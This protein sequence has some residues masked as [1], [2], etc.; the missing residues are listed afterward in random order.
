M[1]MHNLLSTSAER[2]FIKDRDSRFVAVSAGWL[3]AFAGGLSLA[4]VI[5]RTD[6]DFFSAE[7]ARGARAEEL[8]VM[9]TGEPLLTQV[10]HGELVT[11]PRVWAQTLRL[12]LRD[13]HGEI[14]GTYGIGQAAQARVE[15]A[16]SE[17]RE[18]LEASET[19]RAVMFDG[20]PQ[21]MV[22]Y[23]RNTL[24]IIGVNNAAEWIY[25][26][27]HGEWMKMKVT[28]SMPP[29][30]VAGYFA[31]FGTADEEADL[32]VR[33][34]HSRRH[35]YKDGSIHDV[36]VTST[37]V[38][39]DGRPCRVASSQDVTERNLAAAELAA[40]RDAAVEAS[41]VKS[42]FLATISH[43]IRTPMNGVLG[44]TE[45]L[46]DTAL[47]PDQRALATQVSVSGEL[48]L[49][50]I[51][52]ILDIAKIEA[53]QLEVEVT[54]FALRET[55]EQACTVATLQARAK[56]L[57]FNVEIADEV[58]P[59][60]RGDG[61]RLRQVLANLIANAVKF[62]SEGQ[63]SVRATLVGLPTREA[64]GR[65]VRIEVIDT[66]IGIPAAIVD[67]MFEPFT[68]ADPS[69]TRNYGGTGLGLAIARELTQLMGGAIGARSEP[70]NGSTFWIELPL[71]EAREPDDPAAETNGLSR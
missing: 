57:D 44:M 45:L 66:G 35:I 19:M 30:E 59:H 18:R 33:R 17:S 54:D 5:G 14:V 21:P 67:E 42:A 10:A 60:A 2:I 26:W 55:I 16:L 41:N 39:L 28:D 58:P 9:E 70:G 11:H 40:A 34:V 6:F 20:N 69:T 7:H 52:D 51:N 32:G 36:E 43:E 64:A 25:G 8:R 24:Q 49:D 63:I 29:D 31:S 65:A 61:R 71:P 53:G 3:A 38:L 68:Q 47:D 46:L 27:T 50:L 1:L 22:I 56:G 37:D 48:M 62:T 13:E 12:P 4:E 23:D 15:Q